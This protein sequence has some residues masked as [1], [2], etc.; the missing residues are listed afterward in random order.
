[1]MALP[2]GWAA[3]PSEAPRS[4]VEEDIQRAIGLV[5]RLPAFPAYDTTA[6]DGESMLFLRNGHVVARV[7]S[8][9]WARA[10]DERRRVEAHRREVV[11]E[12]EEMSR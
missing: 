1:M 5:W 3:M 10:A 4:S 2:N 12:W 9:D 11:R 8:F 7:P 6:L